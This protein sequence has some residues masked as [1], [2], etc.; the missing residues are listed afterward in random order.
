MHY[1]LLTDD[2][3]GRSVVDSSVI[4]VDHRDGLD[5]VGR[6]NAGI[7]IMLNAA[8]DQ[9]LHVTAIGVATPAGTRRGAVEGKGTGT[10]RQIRLFADDEAVAAYL[11]D[12]GEIDRYSSV[13]VVDCG[14]SGMSI[15]TV[16]PATSRTGEV[17]RSRA[18]SGRDVD[19]AIARSVARAEPDIADGPAFRQGRRDL[20]GACRTAK[21]DPAQ[22]GHSTQGQA[23]HVAG[24]SKVD[25]TAGMVTDAVEPM[26]ERARKAVADGIAAAATQGADPEAVVLVGGLANIPAMRTIVTGHGNRDTVIPV[27]PELASAIGA[28]RLAA[29]RP[30]A[31]R[32]AVIG[33]AVTRG[34]LAP[35]PLAVVAALLGV[36]L[37][38][39]YAVGT[40]L[41]GREVPG[42]AESPTVAEDSP[43]G[44]STA[45]GGTTHSYQGLPEQP[46]TQLSARVPQTDP[47]W[48]DM[49]GWATIELPPPEVSS[50]TTLRPELP[51]GGGA[52]PTTTLVPPPL[53]PQTSLPQTSSPTAAPSTTRPPSSSAETT[54]PESTVPETSS[55]ESPD[56]S[57]QSP[58]PSG[59][60]S[61]SSTEPVAGD[62]AVDSGSSGNQISVPTE[63]RPA[64]SSAPVPEPGTEVPEPENP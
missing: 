22:P 18:I 53:R 24:V 46:R 23:A 61:E 45:A 14:D 57:T 34:L 12:T 44:E 5:D 56:T 10:R 63:T 64:T 60:S 32:Q 48:V 16:D 29:A 2:E 21:E 58:E 62:V 40:T 37:M 59:S 30:A 28:A 6:V 31:A 47:S 42:P 11:A 1:V 17:L 7:D 4:D 19:E 9:D 3:S 20:I 36:V 13:L 15:Y 33:G 8:G 50:T 25:V 49:P 38:T 55:P 52:P 27:T 41:T 54:S 51:A 43:V 35:M 26:V 39:L